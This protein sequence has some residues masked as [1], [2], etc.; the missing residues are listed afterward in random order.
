MAAELGA[1]KCIV[2]PHSKVANF[3][4]GAICHLKTTQ[5]AWKW[6]IGE[7]WVIEAARAAF[8]RIGYI[9]GLYNRAKKELELFV[10]EL[11]MENLM[12]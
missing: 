4:D 3:V 12:F 5:N 9:S 1:G 7:L 8:E 2:Y 6:K 10:S 11:G